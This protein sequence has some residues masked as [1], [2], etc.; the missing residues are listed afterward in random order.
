M[1]A[2]INGLYL[3]SLFTEPLQHNKTKTTKKKDNFSYLW[4]YNSGGGSHLERMCQ[5][6]QVA[7]A[8]GFPYFPFCVSLSLEELHLDKYFYILYT[9]SSKR[10]ARN[11]NCYPETQNAAYLEQKPAWWIV[12]WWE[13]G[14]TR[15]KATQRM[16]WWDWTSGYLRLRQ[17]GRANIFITH[18]KQPWT[19]RSV[20]CT[21]LFCSVSIAPAQRVKLCQFSS[22]THQFFPNASLQQ[23]LNHHLLVTCT[24]GHQNC[25]GLDSSN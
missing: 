6:S 16:T 22:H 19:L 18:I 1:Q 5:R 14:E 10:E 17:R 25:R 24:W 20:K 23:C 21:S 9:Q 15:E 13:T 8:V 3:V 2:A 4:D 12:F 7:I 11:Q